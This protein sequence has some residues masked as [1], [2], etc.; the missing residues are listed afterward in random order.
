M[1]LVTRLLSNVHINLPY[2]S[3]F[4][5]PLTYLELQ[6][7]AGIVDPQI[8]PLWNLSLIHW[9][10]SLHFLNLQTNQLLDRHWV[11]V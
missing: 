7:E 4:C 2:V 5:T 1:V 3:P 6:I 8:M 11:P 10:V 9:S